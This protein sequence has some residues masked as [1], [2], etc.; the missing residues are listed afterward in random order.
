[1]PIIGTVSS[2]FTRFQYN[3]EEESLWFSLEVRIERDREGKLDLRIRIFPDSE[4]TSSQARLFFTELRSDINVQWGLLLPTLNRVS[5]CH[6]QLDDI[7]KVINFS[8][9]GGF[10]FMYHDISEKKS[11]EVFWTIQRIFFELHE[12]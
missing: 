3:F 4:M 6:A 1:M 8:P 2:S 5:E 9:I 7:N 12:A 10:N 11:Q